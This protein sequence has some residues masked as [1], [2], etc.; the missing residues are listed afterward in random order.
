MPSWQIV[1]VIRA[2][3]LQHRLHACIGHIPYQRKVCLSTV[4]FFHHTP[5]YATAQDCY[6]MMHQISV[7]L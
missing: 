3:H 2:G 4:S 5:G 7:H 6:Q 1:Y